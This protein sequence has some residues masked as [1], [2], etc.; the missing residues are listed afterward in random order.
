M[1]IREKDM[2][3]SLCSDLRSHM[4]NC[5]HY[6]RDV[7]QLKLD[8]YG[9]PEDRESNPGL[10]SHVGDLRKSRRILLGVAAGAWTIA[11]I[12]IGTAISHWL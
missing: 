1:T 3:S 7:S 8:I 10:I 4:E 11:T 6:F 5:E 2:I 12:F 9:N